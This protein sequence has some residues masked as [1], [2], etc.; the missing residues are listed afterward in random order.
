MKLHIGCGSIYLK[1]YI[2]IDGFVDK[3]AENCDSEELKL[4]LTT[5][6]NY[7]KYDFCE[8]PKGTISDLKVDFVQSSLPFENDSVDEIVMIQVLEHVQQYYRNKVL[9]EISR[10]LKPGGFFIVGVP[11]IKETARLLGECKEDD[12]EWF[13]RLIHGTQ[14]NEFSHHYYGYT[15]STLIN[16]L[17]QFN[18]V[19]FEDLPNLNFYPAIYLK[20]VK[21]ILCK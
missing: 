2:N 14:R 12:E 17:K 13:I 4:H 15:R 21:E 10:V 19:K 1:D 3:L 5:M 11:D 9:N 6:E 18:F 16:F 8:G 7:Y 20:A